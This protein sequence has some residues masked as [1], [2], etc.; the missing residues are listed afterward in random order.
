M[1]RRPLCSD[2][3]IKGVKAPDC[4]YPHSFDEIIH[5]GVQLAELGQRFLL[6]SCVTLGGHSIEDHQSL[7][8]NQQ[9]ASLSLLRGLTPLNDLHFH[10][11]F[12]T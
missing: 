3:L 9:A 4:L 11:A 2:E 8:E 10:A 6:I 1:R 12:W 5:G 7:P